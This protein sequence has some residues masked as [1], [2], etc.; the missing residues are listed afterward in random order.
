MTRAS[1]NG[2]SSED[3]AYLV[4]M[5]N[6]G[7]EAYPCYLRLAGRNYYYAHTNSLST[8][9]LAMS[10]NGNLSSMQDKYIIYYVRINFDATP[11]TA[12]YGA[13]SDLGNMYSDYVIVSAKN[14]MSGS[15]QTVSSAF[16]YI[17]NTSLP[18]KQ[19]VLTAGEG[20]TIENNVI[21]ATGGSLPTDPSTDGTYFLQNVVSSGTATQSW[22]SIPSANGQ[23]F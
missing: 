5:F 15:E 18:A 1:L 8:Y 2:I 10:N 6:D 17:K 22:V 7:F 4:N 19:D 3:Q 20:I 14:S 21:S 12:V 23:S 11:A 16:A 9:W 13:N